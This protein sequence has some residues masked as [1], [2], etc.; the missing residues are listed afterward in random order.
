MDSY[1]GYEHFM[2]SYEV[3]EDK[4]DIV[5]QYADQTK[6]TALATEHNMNVIES[7]LYKQHQEIMESELPKQ[8][9]KLRANDIFTAV[10]ASFFVTAI[11]AHFTLSTITSFV[12]LGQ[13]VYS[14]YVMKKSIK[15]LQLTDYCLRNADSIQLIRT[16][17]VMQ[18]KL[19]DSGKEAFE[20]DHGFTLNHAHLYTNKDLKTLKK[21]L[22]K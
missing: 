4:N 11:L 14:S 22:R 15:R 3:D 18:P 16:E 19:S 17:S 21:A 13:G 8:K 10:N 1:Q 7:R 12:F 6:S 20:K 2:T 5:I 9:G